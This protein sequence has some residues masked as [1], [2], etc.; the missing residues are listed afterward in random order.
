MQFTIGQH[1][2]RLWL[3]A[4][5]KPFPE[6]ISEIMWSTAEGQHARPLA[7]YYRT[8]MTGPQVWN[9]GETFLWGVWRHGLWEVNHYP[10]RW[11]MIGWMWCQVPL[12]NPWS[13][14]FCFFFNIWNYLNSIQSNDTIWRHRSGTT[15]AHI[16]ACLLDGTKSLPEPMLI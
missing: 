11:W 8:A 14:F 10:V 3:G 12:P 13:M 1:L 6:P 15:L 9:K 16:L 5:I 7:G 2:F 4:G